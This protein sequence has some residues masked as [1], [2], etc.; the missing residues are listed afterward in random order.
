MA[1]PKKRER[2]ARELLPH[3]TWVLHL[4]ATTHDE[5]V[6]ELVNQLVVHGVL[7]LDR[8]AETCG[9]ILER[10]K[11]ASTCIGNGVAIPHYK[12]KY[13]E[14]FGLAVG[15]SHDGIEWSAHDSIPAMV[16]FLWICQPSETPE[17]LALMR[18]IA[19]LARDPDS[20]GT[21][22][23]IK[24]RKSLQALFESVSLEDGTGG[25]R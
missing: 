24:D 10:E 19:S 6:T 25:K 11:V 9:Q 23:A 16:V 5:A 2:T 17:H 14:K 21:L 4:K 18:C 15:I 3:E 22:A 1:K 8:E 12:S 7:P 20:A 13:A